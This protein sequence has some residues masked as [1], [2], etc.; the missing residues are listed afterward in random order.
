MSNLTA[1]MAACLRQIAETLEGFI[2]YYEIPRNH[3]DAELILAECRKAFDLV[4]RSKET[5][6]S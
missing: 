5:T 2:A 4:E 1:E 6:A 3:P